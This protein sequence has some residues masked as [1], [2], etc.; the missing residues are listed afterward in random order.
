[1]TTVLDHL[2]RIR[3]ST[4]AAIDLF[5]GALAWDRDIRHE[6]E[7]NPGPYENVALQASGGW[8][9]RRVDAISHF[10][11]HHTLSNSPHATARHYVKKGGGRPSIPYTIWVT[12]TGE[13]L[14]CADLTWGL[15]HDHTGHRNRHLSVGLAGHLHQHRPSDAQLDAAADVA[16][17]ALQSP[18]MPLIRSI[19]E[20]TGH[21]DWTETQCPG[22][23]EREGPGWSNQ[24]SGNWRVSLYAR[25]EDKT[26]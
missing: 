17:W 24:P 9:V 4:E 3:A 21:C 7:V 14:L 6:L 23:D 8:W 25:I 2:Q 5:T 15:W 16:A 12:Q 18:T 13:V 22:W 1:M 26:G 20:I 10:T 11:Y 19:A